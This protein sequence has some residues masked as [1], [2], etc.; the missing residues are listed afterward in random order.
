[1]LAEKISSFTTINFNDNHENSSFKKYF[2]SVGS[3]TALKV[4]HLAKDQNWTLDS[5]VYETSNVSTLG[6]QFE[7][8]PVSENDVANIILNLP[9][10]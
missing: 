8:Q 6:E 4:G 9:S 3:L 10:I 2:S 1:M 7:F 5:N